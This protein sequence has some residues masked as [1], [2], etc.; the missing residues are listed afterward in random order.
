MSLYAPRNSSPELSQS[1]HV[2][3]QTIDEYLV[4]GAQVVSFCM[5]YHLLSQLDSKLPYFPAYVDDTMTAEDAAHWSTISRDV[6]LANFRATDYHKPAPV[7]DY[8]PGDFGP[9]DVLLSKDN[10]VKVTAARFIAHSLKQ[11]R[12]EAAIIDYEKQL[13]E[14]IVLTTARL[15]KEANHKIWKAIVK[16]LGENFAMVTSMTKI[17]NV[18]GLLAEINSVLHLDLAQ[19]VME[20]RA[21]L[22]NA[23][24][25]KEG[26]CMLLSWKFFVNH[27]VQRLKL[28]GAP[29]SEQECV[30]TFL[31]GLPAI[32][33]SLF[34]QQIYNNKETFVQVAERARAYAAQPDS[35][36]QLEQLLASKQRSGLRAAPQIFGVTSA[37]LPTARACYD[38]ANGNCVRDTCR[39][40]HAVGSP[41][42]RAYPATRKRALCSHCAKPGHTADVCFSIHGYP[43]NQKGGERTSMRGRKGGVSNQ[44]GAVPHVAKIGQ[45]RPPARTYM[46]RAF[47]QQALDADVSGDMAD[48]LHGLLARHKKAKLVQ[49]EDLPESPNY[50][51]MFNALPALRQPCKQSP[52]AKLPFESFARPVKPMADAFVECQ[53]V[54]NK[55]GQTCARE[56]VLKFGDDISSDI[57]KGILLDGG[58]SI[59]ATN[60]IEACFDV[61][62]C[63]ETVSGVGGNFIC[64]TK[65]SL[66]IKTD[67]GKQITLTGVFMSGKFPLTVISESKLLNKGCT[68]TKAGNSGNV[69]A[70][71]GTVLMSIK[72]HLGLFLING[73]V[74]P[75]VALSPVHK[76]VCEPSTTPP[77]AF[78]ARAYSKPE[79]NLDRLSIL[80]RRM[81]H[82][83]FP[84]VAA[85]YGLNLPP[86]FTPPFCEACV[87][88]KSA[89]H[90]HHEG[91]RLEATERYQGLHCDFCGPFP[92]AS[93]SGAK[94][95]LIFIDS[96]TGF[97]WDFYPNSQSEFFDIWHLFMARLDNESRRKNAVSWI[98]S[99]NAKVFSVPRVVAE[100]AE[101]GIRQEFSAPY[102]QWQNGK[103]ERC[104]GT[105]LPLAA[106]SLFQSGLTEAYWEYAIRLAVVSTNRIGEVGSKNVAKGFEH[107]WSKWERLMG[108]SIPTR[109]MA[110]TRLDALSTN[111]FLPN[112]VRSLNRGLSQESIL[113]L[114]RPSKGS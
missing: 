83:S 13:Q 54:E 32:P 38:F 70:S 23:T 57:A 10:K 52:A 86:G 18:Q 69:V 64:Q 112:S 67:L 24:F 59:H 4:W 29:Y 46:T 19:D 78:L 7:L 44:Q 109:L 91:A 26:L 22:H 34:R 81:Q 11:D 51:Y 21:Q 84:R 37:P 76:F 6:V 103:A 49:K 89:N 14:Q 56:I 8:N 9:Q 55:L 17:G 107:S 105:V 80:H 113:V 47:A 102:S 36:L 68:I 97:I 73:H 94:Y 58:A 88:A 93:L 43:P 110:S 60:Q 101:R 45:Q 27:Q 77:A 63:G 100:C 74:V 114:P 104:F 90:P 48:M 40:V 96:F 71:D 98:R 106:A 79:S 30:A 87:M 16:T 35:K 95:L 20:T 15:Q 92:C 66:I 75:A 50:T 72:P 5:D 42:T 53:E 1:G 61:V 111:I 31:K 12:A 3:L 39:F 25:E 2:K 108:K 99:D 28:L 33:F 85:S 65:G 82:A 62:P 41:A